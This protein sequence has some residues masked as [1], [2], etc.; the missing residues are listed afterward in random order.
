MGV[1][2]VGAAV[3]AALLG[4]GWWT[5]RAPEGARAALGIAVGVLTVAFLVRPAPARR[6]AGAR[7][8]RRRA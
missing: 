5:A 3:L 4:A 2:V 1:L 7:A 6:R 8:R